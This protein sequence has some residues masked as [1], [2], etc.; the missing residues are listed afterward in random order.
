M[1][2]F[3]SIDG[4]SS[5][6][7]TTEIIN[8]IIQAERRNAVLLEQ[9]QE[10]KTGIITAYKALQAKLL[11]LNAELFSLTRTTTFDAGKLTVSDETYLSGSVDGR[12]SRGSYDV[13]VLSLARNHQIASQGFSDESM[14]L[15]GTG[16]ISLQV[17]NGSEVTIDIDETNNSLIG[18][19]QAINGARS[20][21][22]ASIINDGTSSNPY[23]LLL[24]ADRTGIQNKL[25]ISSNLSGG[26]NLNYDSASFDEPEVI[27][28]DSGSNAQVSLGASADY[29][30]TTNKEYS[31]TVLGTGT[32]T[33]GS[34]DVEIGWTD[35]TNSGTITVSVA[36][37]EVALTGDGSEGLTLSLS[38]G[39]LTAGDTFQVGTFAPLVQEA[40]D[41]K[42]SFGGTGGSPIIVTSDSNT[43]EDAIGGVTLNVAQLTPPGTSVSVLT[44]LDTNGIKDKVQKFIERYND[45]VDFIEE[46]NTYNQETTESGILFG[47]STLWTTRYAM[48]GAVGDL[49]QGIESEFSH[50]YA[51]GI[52][53]K[54]DGH[55]AVTNSARLDEALRNNIDDV[56]KLFTSAGFSS[57]AAIQFIS[58]TAATNIG[59]DYEINITTAASQGRL[60]GTSIE[61]PAVTPLTLTAENNTLRLKIDG[62]ESEDIRLTAKTYSSVTEL[63]NELQQKID[64]DSKIGSRGLTVEWVDSGAAGYLTLTAASYGDNSEVDWIT[65]IENSAGSVLGLAAGTSH[66]GTNVAGTINGEEAEGAGQLLK[67]KDGNETTE[68]LVL[69]ITLDETQ[70]IDGAEGTITITKGVAARLRDVVESITRSGDGSLDR[71]IKAVQSQVETLQ[72]RIAEI[73]ERLAVRRESLFRQFYQMETALSQFSATSQYLANQLAGINQNWGLGRSNSTNFS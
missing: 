15:L 47:D 51:I 53:T 65:G 52:R 14:A 40:T 61:N 25:E 6:L 9:Q 42:I 10:E 29:T 3:N 56:A 70:L 46:Q 43:F 34:G 39:Q 38:S 12:V 5:G 71:R 20:G 32:Q 19:K 44:D 62:L 36:D 17:G 64:T 22:T 58:S 8:T 31:F 67:G 4:L 72:D 68:G 55:L 27:S 7:N 37:T 21:V 33:I 63:V 50:L 49:V 69:K 24:S 57:H 26:I 45:V 13:Q 41:A 35:G 28:F 60:E 59:Q 16:T 18:I 48:S 23:R 54:S 30:G 1:P 2:G 66:Q 73:D 11:A